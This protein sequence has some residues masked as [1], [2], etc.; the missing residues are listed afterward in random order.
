MKLVTWLEKCTGLNVAVDPSRI[1]YDPKTGVCDLAAA[2][3][4]DVDRSGRPGRRKPYTLVANVTGHSLWSDGDR[5]FYVSNGSLYEFFEDYTSRGLRSGIEPAARMSFT[6]GGGDIYYT[7]GFQNGV[8]KENAS[9][10]WVGNTY[11]GPESVYYVSTYPPI[12]HLVEVHNAYML[13]A[14]NNIVYWSMP[15]SYSWYRKSR[16][17]HTFPS[18]ILM[19]ESLDIGAWVSCYHGVYWCHGPDPFVWTKTKKSDTPA[20]PGTAIS[21][22]SIGITLDGIGDSAVIWTSPDGIYIG[23][24][25]GNLRNLTE[26]RLEYPSSM[27]GAAV[28]IKNKYVTS[29][30]P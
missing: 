23:D 19:M 8:I 11:T 15:Y 22:S 24:N 12:G 6:N 18:D 20:I 27:R 25:K 26:E 9:Y 16:D 4:I 29:M 5:A 10:S 14:E 2:W 7:N 3:N 21:S 30:R 28:R 17:R 13:V 1:N